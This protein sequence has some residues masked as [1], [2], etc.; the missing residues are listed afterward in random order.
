M[1]IL[2]INTCH[3]RRG[4]AD[5]VY[6]NTSQLLRE[7]GHIV[8]NFSNL[9]RLNI[10][11]TNNSY[12]VNEIDYFSLSS[13]KKALNIP[14]FIY[15]SE[16][17]EKIEK[18]IKKEKPDIAHIHLYKGTLTP[19]ILVALKQNNI[20][21]V[22]TL[23]DYGLLCPHNTFL[24]GK[25]MICEKCLITNNSINCIVNKCNRN[26]FLLSTV[27]AFEFAVHKIV[28]P[29]SKYFDKLIA[30][31]NFGLQIHSRKAEFKEKIVHLYNFYPK[32]NSTLP[33]T[34]KGD[35]FLSFGR[36]SHE[37][38]IY[39]L[40]KSWK[41]LNPEI[42]L[43][44]VGDGPILYDV[45]KFIKE[46][47]LTNVE[48]LG[49]KKDKSLNEIINKASFIIVPSEC[50]ENNPLAIIEAY[51]NGKPVIAS[52]TGGI[53]EIV[54]ENKTGYFFEMGN[55]DQLSEVVNLASKISADEY[56][57]MSKNSRKF[58][59]VNFSE[60]KHY[61]ELMNIYNSLIIK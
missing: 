10:Q 14:R 37:K 12:F 7:R 49:Y 30:V 35:Y 22:I 27:S 60:D 21:T 36:L 23:H 34:N 45:M 3:Y 61:I 52:R 42:L 53:P 1:K 5:V 58:A 2:Q 29:F 50:Y 19:S 17:K 47:K 56:S 9:S 54:V 48:I 25:N 18:L 57:K 24:D 32:L 4:G 55:V 38:G 41:K 28:F 43:K 39:T 44:I 46:N 31:S 26:N 16:A 13:L 40:I 20:P 15:S 11:D 6:L 51:S 59:E 8:I 33:N